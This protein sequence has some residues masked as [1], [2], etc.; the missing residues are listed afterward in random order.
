MERTKGVEWKFIHWETFFL[1]AGF[2]NRLAS[3]H[4]KEDATHA[5]LVR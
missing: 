3:A 2:G 5:V 1:P 4:L